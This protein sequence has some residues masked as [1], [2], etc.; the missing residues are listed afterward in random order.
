MLNQLNCLKVGGLVLG[1]IGT[2][3]AIVNVVYAYAVYEDF[4]LVEH[5]FV[6]SSIIGDAPEHIIRITYVIISIFDLV[7]AA[8]L[9]AGILMKN[10]YMLLPWIVSSLLEIV[11]TTI[12]LSSSLIPAILLV[13]I[14]GGIIYIWY[15]IVSLYTQ[16][17]AEEE[18]NSGVQMAYVDEAPSTLPPYSVLTID[19]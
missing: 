3:V 18:A 14:F 1:I 12:E 6:L 7:C 4:S 5:N 9:I 15:S 11:I 17:K 10:K 13:S 19:K 8:L 16:M 2:L